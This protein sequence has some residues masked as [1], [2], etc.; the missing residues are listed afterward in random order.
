MAAPQNLALALGNQSS[1]G[2]SNKSNLPAPAKRAIAAAEDEKKGL[3]AQLARL[4]KDKAQTLAQVTVV[5]GQA[6]HSAETLGTGFAAS[7]ITG[8]R[9]GSDGMKVKGLDTRVLLGLVLGLLGL[10]Q[11][12]TGSKWGTHSLAVGSGLLSVPVNELGR[13]VGER[14][15]SRAPVTAVVPAPAPASAAPAMRGAPRVMP[16]PISGGLTPPPNVRGAERTIVL[17]A[18]G[19]RVKARRQGFVQPDEDDDNE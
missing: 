13:E 14:M 18:R 12:F 17:P 5:G 11:S 8:W 7:V 15:R 9:G 19:A 1:G 16:A 3:S 10:Y 2:S 6:L 4:K